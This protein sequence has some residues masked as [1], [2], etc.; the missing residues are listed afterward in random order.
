MDRRGLIGL[1]LAAALVAGCVT[2]PV[3]GLGV[4]A[5]ESQR[6][7]IARGDRLRILTQDGKRRTVR[8]E[9]ADTLALYTP[10]ETIPVE[11]LVFVERIRASRSRVLL[12]TGA[13]VL[14]VLI[15]PAVP[16][17][18]AGAILAVGPN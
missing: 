7:E 18:A 15:V 13:A 14:V 8:I 5:G 11:D 1:A 10:S 2:E 12:G 4:A 6:I 16:G 17:A 9:A 3:P